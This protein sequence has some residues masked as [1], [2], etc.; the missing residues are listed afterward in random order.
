MTAPNVPQPAAERIVPPAGHPLV[1]GVVPG[2]PELVART[3]AA[4]SAALGGVPLHFA[5]ADPSRVVDEELPDGDVR[6]SGLSP[7]AADD[8]W[9]E[10][11]E[12]LRGYLS[13]VLAGHAGPWRFHYLAGRPDRA[14]THLARTVDA[15]AYVIGAQRPSATQLLH[16]VV[17]GSVAL[18]LSR[19][20]HRPVLVVPLAVVDWKA[21]APW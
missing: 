13:E 21:S 19:H 17:T 18:G 11:D 8:A 12:R 14:L 20:Q 4:W 15:A 5:Y 9:V 6:H 16:D 7:D 1:V 2:Q 10:R 3:A